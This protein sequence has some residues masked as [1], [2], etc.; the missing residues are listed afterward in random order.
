MFSYQ[1]CLA[2]ND[3][4]PL[5]DLSQSKPQKSPNFPSANNVRGLD[6]WDKPSHASTYHINSDQVIKTFNLPESS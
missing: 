6:E 4:P 5:R 1:Y 2:N 3:S